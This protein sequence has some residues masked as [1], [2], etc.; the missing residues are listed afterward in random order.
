MPNIEDVEGIGPSYGEKLRT[1]GVSSTDELLKSGA[2]PAGRKSLA[3]A[4]GISD[5]LVLRWVNQADLYRIKGIGSEYAEL[6]EAAGVD[7]VPE[8]AQRV[9]ANL[10]AKL[11]EANQAKNLVRRL[12]TAAEVESWVAEAKSLPRLVQY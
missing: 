10:Y 3:E 12:P 1:A 2:T 5:T 4:S 9:P 11:G 8:L 7:S 6:L